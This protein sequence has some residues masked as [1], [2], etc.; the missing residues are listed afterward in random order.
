MPD[1]GELPDR[2]RRPHVLG[3]VGQACFVGKSEGRREMMREGSRLT[4]GTVAPEKAR[5]NDVG[6]YMIRR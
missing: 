1:D 2:K 6:K 3:Q 4:L 5:E